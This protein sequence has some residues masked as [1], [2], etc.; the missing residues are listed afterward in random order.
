MHALAD[1]AAAPRRRLLNGCRTGV[2]PPMLRIGVTARAMCLTARSLA[3]LADAISDVLLLRAEAQ[4]IRI[5]ALAVIAGVQNHVQRPRPDRSVQQDPVQPMN[6][7][8][9]LLEDDI[10]VARRTN[11]ARVLDAP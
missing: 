7:P 10:A 8:V 1:Y 6:L 2:Q 11:V 9:F 5:D 3:I 4:V